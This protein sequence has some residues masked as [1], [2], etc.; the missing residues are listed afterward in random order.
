M[1]KISKKSSHGGRRSGA[2]R[3]PK[4]DE[5]K[6]ILLPVRIPRAL[7]LKLDQWAAAN[8]LSRTEAIERA[9]RRLIGR[10]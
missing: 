7:R 10:S 3:K 6:R 4:P 1:K 9:I 5:K 2:G 8:D